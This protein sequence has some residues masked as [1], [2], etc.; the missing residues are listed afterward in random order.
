M[1]TASWRL[2]FPR[3]VSCTRYAWN[4]EKCV[5][6]RISERDDSKCQPSSF[7]YLHIKRDPLF[8]HAS[9]IDSKFRAFNTRAAGWAR[10]P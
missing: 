5:D 1:L 4:S 10:R 3:A 2:M 9:K 7:G 8:S 6:L